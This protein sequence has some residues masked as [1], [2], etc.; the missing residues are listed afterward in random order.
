MALGLG[1]KAREPNSGQRWTTDGEP[2]CATWPAKASLWAARNLARP[3]RLRTNSGGEQVD[4]GPSMLADDDLPVV[5]HAD[6]PRWFVQFTFLLPVT[7]VGAA[8][9]IAYDIACCF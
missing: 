4:T 2:V 3:T 1:A 7:F 5:R 9:G 8:M 6:K